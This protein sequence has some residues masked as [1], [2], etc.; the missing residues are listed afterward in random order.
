MINN[1]ILT[2]LDSSKFLGVILDDHLSFKPHIQYIST[3]IAKNLGILFKIK[4]LLPEHI[5]LNLYYSLIYPY[6]IYGNNVWGSNYPSRLQCLLILQKRALRFVFNLPYRAHVTHLFQDKHILDI[7]EISNYKTLCFM[8][9]YFNNKLPPQFNDFFKPILFN[10]SNKYRY[11]YQMPYC[12]TNF[13][14]FSIIYTGP[15][16]WNKLPVDLKLINSFELFKK[17]LK[18]YLLSNKIRDT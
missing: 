1:N 15:Y 14:K 7:F 12:R 6:L 18:R 11:S 8:Y 17:K 10:Y 9:K 3:K 2:H 13:S 5:R 16:H 4:H